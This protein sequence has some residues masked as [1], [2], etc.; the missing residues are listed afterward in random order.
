MHSSFVILSALSTIVPNKNTRKY[1]AHSNLSSLCSSKARKFRGTRLNIK[2]RA[3]KQDKLGLINSTGHA[4]TQCIKLNFSVTVL[5]TFGLM[6]VGTCG[7]LRHKAAVFFYQHQE[8]RL[9]GGFHTGSP[10]FTDFLSNLTNLAEI[11]NELAQKIGS[12]S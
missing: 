12:S 9:L 6:K 7:N 11:R 2:F 10:P 8:S 5:L 3:D 1:R 4:N